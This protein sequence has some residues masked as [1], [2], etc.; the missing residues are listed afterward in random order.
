MSELGLLLAVATVIA[1]ASGRAY[2]RIRWSNV[3]LPQLA[4]PSQ[5]LLALVARSLNWGIATAV[6]RWGFALAGLA[7][8]AA[9]AATGI[10]QRCLLTAAGTWWILAVLE[11]GIQLARR[12]LPAEQLVVLPL[13][14]PCKHPSTACGNT[15]DGG[16]P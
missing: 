13:V 16:Q 8:L 11:V 6:H 7:G 10:G 9:T 4:V 15:D 2:I 3:R 12:G 1:F 5:R 14:I